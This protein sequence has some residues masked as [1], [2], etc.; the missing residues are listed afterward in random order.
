[1]FS[2]IPFPAGEFASNACN[3]GDDNPGNYHTC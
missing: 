2:K 3:G 1:M